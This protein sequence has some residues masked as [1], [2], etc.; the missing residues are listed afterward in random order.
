MKSEPRKWVSR[1][2]AAQAQTWKVEQS[3]RQEQ[4]FSRTQADSTKVT[5][6]AF[7]TASIG[8]PR[9]VMALRPETE[10][11]QFIPITPMFSPLWA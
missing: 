8:Y 5:L 11:S 1:C 7:N 2:P 10:G 9:T 4:Q 3:S 6:C